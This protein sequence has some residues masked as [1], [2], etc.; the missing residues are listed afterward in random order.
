[1]GIR[2]FFIA[3]IFALPLCI[4]GQNQNNL[5]KDRVTIHFEKSEENPSFYHLN[6]EAVTNDFFGTISFYNTEGRVIYQMEEVE[7]P[8]S[9]GY[10]VIDVV[11]FPKGKIIIEIMVDDVSFKNEISL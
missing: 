2:H 5:N 6:C 9:P 8:F 10:H 7:I 3:I 4:F 11:E 1:M